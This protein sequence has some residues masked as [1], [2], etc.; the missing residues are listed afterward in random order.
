MGEKKADQKIG[1][2]IYDGGMWGIPQLR[3][4]L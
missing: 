2:Y 4:I 3:K 1:S